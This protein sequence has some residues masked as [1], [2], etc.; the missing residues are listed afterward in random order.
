MWSLLGQLVPFVVAAAA[1]PLFLRALGVTRFGVLTLA[2]VF[3]G[4]FTLFDFGLGRAVTKFAAE[5]YETGNLDELPVIVWTS[6]LL[7]LILGLAGSALLWLLAPILIR[8]LAHMTPAV[9]ADATAALQVLALAMPAVT[10]TTGLRG[11][12]EAQGRFDL[13][14]FGRIGLAVFTLLTPL[15][16]LLFSN[17]LLAAAIGTLAGRLITWALHVGLCAATVPSLRTPR[18]NVALIRPLLYFGGWTTL[19]SVVGPLLFPAFAGALLG[20]LGRARALFTK[21]VAY[22]FIAIVPVIALATAGAPEML[23]LWVGWDFSH[24]SA[25]VLQ[26]LLVSIL[27]NSMAFIPSALMPAAGRPDIIAKLQL[28]EVL[29]YLGV[30]LWLVHA[31]G[32]VGAAIAW[33]LRAS[34]DSMLLY[35][36]GLRVLELPIRSL[37]WPAALLGG[38]AASLLLL[39][40]PAPLWV[41]LA[42]AITITATSVA[43]AWRTLLSAAD[44]REALTALRLSIA[45]LLGGVR[46]GHTV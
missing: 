39:L 16:L 1:F 21:A 12:L 37:A 27:V 43:I 42:L 40:G 33:A 14:T 30:M 13:S 46:S 8:S 32:L 7:M 9:G 34:V 18:F 19:Y 24:H 38:T 15:P 41:R 22:L 23:A 31:H 17:T 10:L 25:A 4:Y 5:R 35:A 28:V 44:R 29:P 36:L 20:S 26:I 6:Q 2:W 3:V 45:Q 11:L